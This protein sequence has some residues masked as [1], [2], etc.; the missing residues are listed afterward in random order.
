MEKKDI[1]II[2]SKD[3]KIDLSKIIDNFEKI[4]SV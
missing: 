2:G 3:Y 1:I 4:S